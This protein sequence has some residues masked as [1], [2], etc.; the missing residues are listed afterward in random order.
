MN[1]VATRAV[2]A[3][4][5]A[6][7]LLHV[8]PALVVAALQKRLIFLSEG[9]ESLYDIV[10]G[11]VVVHLNFDVGNERSI[12]I[13]EIEFVVAKNLLPVGDVAVHCRKTAVYRFEQVA[14]NRLVDV[15]A[16]E[17]AL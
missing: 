16:R 1:A 11:V 5:F 6:V 14:V 10:V 17:S 8:N 12:Y 3:A 13:V 7:G 4:A 2:C 9:S 15:L